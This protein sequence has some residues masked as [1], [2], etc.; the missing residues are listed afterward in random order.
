[1]AG[2]CY[3]HASDFDNAE[4]YYLREGKCSATEISTVLK[5]R[6]W[7]IKLVFE[8]L[9]YLYLD[10]E[11]VSPATPSLHKARVALICMLNVL[12]LEPHIVQLITKSQLYN[13]ADLG[14]A[15][16]QCLKSCSYSKISKVLV[17]ALHVQ[18]V[19][20]FPRHVGQAIESWKETTCVQCLSLPC[21]H[22]QTESRHNGF[23]KSS[24]S[25]ATCLH[26]FRVLCDVQDVV[27]SVSVQEG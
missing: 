8:S 15:C 2:S 22:I 11:K 25:G 10:H 4:R 17:K 12:G 1:M 6:E 7:E 9:V 24:F 14:K 13:G 20:Y 3:G 26:Q 16:T 18:E 19:H 5:E 21:N 23:H 27:V